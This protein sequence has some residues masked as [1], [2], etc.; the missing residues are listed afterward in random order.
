MYFA[1]TLGGESAEK[2]WNEAR[3]M[4]G[5]HPDDAFMHHIEVKNTHIMLSEEGFVKVTTH[6]AGKSE[7]KTCTLTMDASGNITLES[8]DT[9]TLK[10]K[11]IIL[12][13]S[14]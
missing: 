13:G 4:A 5:S 11:N 1:S 7:D 9:I 3:L 2:H 12:D 6:D 14:T 8:G 10:A